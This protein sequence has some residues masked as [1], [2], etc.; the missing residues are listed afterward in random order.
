MMPKII[1][2]TLIVLLVSVST[3]ASVPAFDPL[4]DYR[5]AARHAFD[6]QNKYTL[7]M[8]LLAF[9]WSRDADERTRS[10]YAHQGR[11][12]S[13]EYLGNELIGT[14]VPGVL[15]G[16]GFWGFG[17][18]HNRPYEVGAGHAQLE[19][20]LA[21][22]VLTSALKWAVQR[23]RP[24]RSDKYSLPSG[25]TSTV[26]ASAMTLYEFYGWKAGIPGVI[27]VAL[28]ALS[29][30]ADDRHWL[31]DTVAGATLGAFVGHAVARAHLRRGLSQSMTL[32]A[33][34]LIFPEN[35]GVRLVAVFNRP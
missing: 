23:E 22:F 9:A 15:S 20:L 1:H 6:K 29:R 35:D 18:V 30:V 21:T 13:G 7:G 14:G 25:H 17:A 11:L 33:S 4:A 26:S 16:L 24:D 12:G 28:T 5:E 27:L 31:S 19:A 8:G 10:A 32:P 3:R 2:R 34:L